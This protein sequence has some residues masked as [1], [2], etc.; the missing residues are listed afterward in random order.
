MVHFKELIKKNNTTE[1]F[2]FVNKDLG[3]GEIEKKDI[4]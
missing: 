2:K 4:N 1:L 3:T